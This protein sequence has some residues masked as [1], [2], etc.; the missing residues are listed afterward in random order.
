VFLTKYF[1]QVIRPRIMRCA[2]HGA[3]MKKKR[4]AY[5]FLVVKPQGKRPLGRHRHRWAGTSVGLL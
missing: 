3:C 4:I 5:R 2:D 1:T